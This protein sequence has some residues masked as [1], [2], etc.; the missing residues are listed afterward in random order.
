MITTNLV[1]SGITQPQPLGGTAC[2]ATICSQIFRLSL[3][4]TG[5]KFM[6]F[7]SIVAKDLNSRI[8]RGFAILG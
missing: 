3:V 7:R 5:L 2:L 1:F 6:R 4:T 8:V